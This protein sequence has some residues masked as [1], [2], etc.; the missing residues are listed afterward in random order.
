MQ[1]QNFELF[2][3][4]SKLESYSFKLLFSDLRNDNYFN[5]IQ[6]VENDRKQS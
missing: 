5:K 3:I 1:G 2:W 6:I 4:V